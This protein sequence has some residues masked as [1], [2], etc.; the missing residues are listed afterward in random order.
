MLLREGVDSGWIPLNVTTCSFIDNGKI[1]DG[2]KKNPCTQCLNNCSINWLAQKT[3]I[4]AHMLAVSLN[5]G[6]FEKALQSSSAARLM[7]HIDVDQS[8]SLWCWSIALSISTD[9]LSRWDK[10]WGR[11][12]VMESAFT[13]RCGTFPSYISLRFEHATFQRKQTWEPGNRNVRDRTVPF[14]VYHLK[15]GININ[16]VNI[17]KHGNINF[18]S[19]KWRGTDI[20]PQSV[21]DKGTFQSACMQYA[22]RFIRKGLSGKLFQF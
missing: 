15:L 4:W 11:T 20:R 8:K 19:F 14:G 22:W 5:S 2:M 9:S 3:V 7:L 17:N 18:L 12:L 13:S 6:L 1:S 10:F 21:S 16:F